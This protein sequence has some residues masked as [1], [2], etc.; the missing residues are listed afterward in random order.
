QISFHQQI[1]SLSQSYPCPR[2]AGS[3]EPYGLT[4]TF[5][6]NNCERG[7]VP[8]RGS[9]L[10]CPSNRMGWKIAPTF[11]WDGLRWHW[12]GT[13]A[14]TRQL[15]AIVS[16]FATPLIMLNLAMYLGVGQTLPEWCSPILLTAVLGLLTVQMIYFTCWDFDFLTKRRI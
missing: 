13:T 15:M 4:E 8:L 7:F 9:R 16:V 3:L 6:C 5:K 10:L 12:A 1:I 11:W 2:C 14:T